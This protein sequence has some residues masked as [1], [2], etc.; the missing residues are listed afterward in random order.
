MSSAPFGFQP[1]SSLVVA[2]QVQMAGSE[3]QLRIFGAG[4][5]MEQPNRVKR[6]HAAMFAAGS[7][8]AACRPVATM[9]GGNFLS[10]GKIHKF[11]QYANLTAG[12]LFYL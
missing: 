5:V 9:P 1:S 10:A 2:R 7:G 6:V 3:S 8:C 4:S 12:I 11:V